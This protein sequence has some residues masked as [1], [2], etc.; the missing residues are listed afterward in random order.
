MAT[1]ITGAGMVGVQVA[2]GLVQRG[3]KAILFDLFPQMDNIR[4]IVDVTKIK[5][6]RGDILEPLDLMK[7]MKEE[8]VDRVIHTASLF[9]LRRGMQEK[10]LAGIK[11]NI[12]GTANVL[13]AAKIMALKRVV[14]TSSQHVASR[15]LAL[16]EEQLLGEDFSFACLSGRSPY[17]YSTT[18]LACEQLGLNYFDNFG[19]DFVAVRFSGVFG[20]W[21]GAVSGG[22]GEKMKELVTAA[23]IRKPITLDEKHSW[24]GKIDVVYSKDAANSTILAC[25]A[26]NPKNRVYNICMGRPYDLLEIVKF[27]HKLLPKSKVRLKGGKEK[28]LPPMRFM[29]ISK[30]REELGYKPQYDM[31][32]ALKDYIDWLKSNPA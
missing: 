26:N 31:E 14:F 10:P 9:G 24:L 11:V 22:G 8:G 13:E 19:V 17:F 21:K 20:P 12:L 16:S 23:L 18:K 2:Q 28:V 15:P 32:A 27:L 29:D 7:V 4:A 1:L 6:V 30:A 25:Y 3:E 5:V